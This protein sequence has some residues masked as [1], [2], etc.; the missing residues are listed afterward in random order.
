MVRFPFLIAA[1]V[2]ALCALCALPLLGNG[3]SEPFAC[4]T[5][6]A[7]ATEISATNAAIEADIF[8]SETAIYWENE[9]VGTPHQ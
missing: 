7:L 5:R 1:I 6:C 3:G 2:P 4:D 9:M 8:A